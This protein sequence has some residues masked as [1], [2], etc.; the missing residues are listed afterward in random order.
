MSMGELKRSLSLAEHDE[1]L[2]D[3]E[4]LLQLPSRH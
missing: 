1:G 4:K 3:N 2:P